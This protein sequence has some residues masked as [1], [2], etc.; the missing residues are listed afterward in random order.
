MIC[1]WKTWLLRWFS[2]GRLVG[3][4]YGFC[5]PDPFANLIAPRARRIAPQQAQLEAVFVDRIVSRLSLPRGA[6]LQRRR[7]G[8]SVAQL[9]RRRHRE[10]RNARR[11]TRSN[12]PYAS[13]YQPMDCF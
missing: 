3:R 10:A 5:M 11:R 13:I 9:V 2:P 8:L 7:G 4:G 6:G 12:T 1:A